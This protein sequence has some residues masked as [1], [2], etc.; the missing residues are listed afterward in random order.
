M[1]LL[2]VVQRDANSIPPDPVLALHAAMLD[3]QPNQRYRDSAILP[4]GLDPEC[5]TLSIEQFLDARFLRQRK[6]NSKI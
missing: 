4:A 1:G 3:I 6:R 2:V 5:L